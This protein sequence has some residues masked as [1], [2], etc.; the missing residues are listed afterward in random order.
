MD[1]LGPLKG[2]LGTKIAIICC[3]FRY[4]FFI[5]KRV[6]SLRSYEFTFS[7]VVLTIKKAHFRRLSAPACDDLSACPAQAEGRQ[8]IFSF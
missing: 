3:N 2:I 8:V 5:P 1:K 4:P 7:L 6:F